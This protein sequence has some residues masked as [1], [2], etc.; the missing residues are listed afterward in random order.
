[1]AQ[2]HHEH[3]HVQLCQ[4]GESRVSSSA[5]G[6]RRAFQGHAHCDAFHRGRGWGAI[7]VFFEPCL[8]TFILGGLFGLPSGVC[9][10]V[11]VC[12]CVSVF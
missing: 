6:F 10:C 4:P 12:V 1:M 2:Q 8:F 9:V 5:G 7:L 3:H 11:C